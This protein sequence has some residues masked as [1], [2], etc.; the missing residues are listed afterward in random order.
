LPIDDCQLTIEEPPPAAVINGKDQTMGT[1]SDPKTCQTPGCIRPAG[2]K[3]QHYC[4]RQCGSAK[5]TPGQARREATDRKAAQRLEDGQAADPTAG[6]KPTIAEKPAEL[7]RTPTDRHL[8]TAGEGAYMAQR[9][10]AAL[11]LDQ[12]CEIVPLKTPRGPALYCAKTGRVA[13]FEEGGLTSGA[14]AIVTA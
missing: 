8:M 9:I 12:D 10:L 5:A 11:G 14:L 2:H 1:K 3:G 6:G 4:R 13:V 7:T